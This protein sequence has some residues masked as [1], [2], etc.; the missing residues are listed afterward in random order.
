ML[1][2]VLYGWRKDLIG[3][4]FCNFLRYKDLK[5][6][7]FEW[8]NVF[9]WFNKFVGKIIFLGEWED[10]IGGGVLEDIFTVNYNG[11]L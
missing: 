9:V 6:E 11:N 8:R 3:F 5:C 2:E 4:L 1:V 7:S 10:F